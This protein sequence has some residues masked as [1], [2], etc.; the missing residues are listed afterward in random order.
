MK[1]LETSL[2]DSSDALNWKLFLSFA[3]QLYN[4]VIH[5]AGSHS[6]YIM[7]TAFLDVGLIVD[8]IAGSSVVPVPSA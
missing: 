7:R 2:K 6:I 1:N 8:S 4:F 5:M 3:V